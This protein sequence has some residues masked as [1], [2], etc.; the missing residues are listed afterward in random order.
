M[1]VEGLTWHPLVRSNL[2]GNHSLFGTVHADMIFHLMAT[3]V[4]DKQN[5]LDYTVRTSQRRGV[6]GAMARLSIVVVPEVL[7]KTIRRRLSEPIKKWY[8]SGD[9]EDWERERAL[10]LEDP[11]SY[12]TYLRTGAKPRASKPGC[13]SQTVGAPE[14]RRLLQESQAE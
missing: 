10:L 12:L 9:R 7:R 5:A 14:H 13:D 6:V 8:R 1:F 2:G 11:E 4:I 3:A